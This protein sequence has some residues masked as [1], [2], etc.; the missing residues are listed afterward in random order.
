MSHFYMVIVY[1][2]KNGIYRLPIHFC[3]LD[4]LTKLEILKK[5]NIIYIVQVTALFL[6]YFDTTHQA[7]SDESV[8]VALFTPSTKYLI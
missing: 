4:L 7:L 1:V 3:M 5:R 2:Y 6:F 8:L